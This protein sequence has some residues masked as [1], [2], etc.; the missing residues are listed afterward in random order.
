M[1]ISWASCLKNRYRAYKEYKY[2]SNNITFLLHAIDL[3]LSISEKLIPSYITSKIETLLYALVEPMPDEDRARISRTLDE[4]KHDLHA[5]NRR[6]YDW[7]EVNE[8]LVLAPFYPLPKDDADLNRRM[9]AYVRGRLS[10]SN[11]GGNG[12]VYLAQSR[13]EPGK[14]YCIKVNRNEFSGPSDPALLEWARERKVMTDVCAGSDWL[15]SARD[16]PGLDDPASAENRT[17]L[18]IAH[19]VEKDQFVP[20]NREWIFPWNEKT[21]RRLLVADYVEGESLFYHIFALRQ[22][23]EICFYRGDIEDATALYEAYL[24]A[25]LPLFAGLLTGGVGHIHGR[26]HIH[27]DIKTGNILVSVGENGN[28]VRLLLID[29]GTARELDGQGRVM[30]VP[31]VGTTSYLAPEVASDAGKPCFADDGSPCEHWEE[32]QSGRLP[33]CRKFEGKPGAERLV[34]YTVQSDLY[35][36]GMVLYEIVN[37][38]QARPRLKEDEKRKGIEVGRHERIRRFLREEREILP[39]SLFKTLRDKLDGAWRERLDG[40]QA[41]MAR[42]LSPRPEKRYASAR[43]MADDFKTDVSEAIK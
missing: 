32:C 22:K 9:K 2:D 19:T 35:M 29:Y 10:R 12:A 4:A 41:V 23:V 3:Y 31:A 5:L 15:I 42:A 40:C 36:C 33:V 13:H 1:K 7:K 43:E 6:C 11:G 14:I 25:M 26:N 30:D 17:W 18:G 28:P 20:V 38:V 8:S 27:R 39:S 16:I 24:K 34:P 21:D 37:L